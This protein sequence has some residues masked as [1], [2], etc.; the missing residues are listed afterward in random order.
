MTF[1]IEFFGGYCPFKALNQDLCL[2]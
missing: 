1:L 2:I